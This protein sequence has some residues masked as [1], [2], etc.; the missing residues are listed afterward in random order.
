MDLPVGSIIVW[1]NNTI[2]EGWHLCDGTDGTP[3][4]VDKFILGAAADSELK[5]AGGSVTHG[6]GNSPTGTVGAHSHPGKTFNL[7]WASSGTAILGGSGTKFAHSTHKHPVTIEA[8]SY[9]GSHNHSVATTN[10][11]NHLPP[12]I[13]LYYIIRIT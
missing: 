10:Q 2:P 12:Y 6:H 8:S 13:K 11:A 3:D 1:A 9:D 7:G 4:L 5:A